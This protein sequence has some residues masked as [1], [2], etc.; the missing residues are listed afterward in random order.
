MTSYQLIFCYCKTANNAG[1]LLQWQT[2]SFFVSPNRRPLRPLFFHHGEAG[3]LSFA[4]IF[5]LLLEYAN[6][7]DI[8]GKPNAS[9][10]H[11]QHQLFTTTT[12]ATSCSLTK[13]CLY[14]LHSTAFWAVL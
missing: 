7:D 5:W 11:S 9:F 1:K 3:S 12:L 10:I 8:M 4:C 6:H 13:E 14:S 2:A